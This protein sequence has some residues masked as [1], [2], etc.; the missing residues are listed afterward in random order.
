MRIG[1]LQAVRYRVVRACGFARA[2]GDERLTM[3]VSVA[4]RARLSVLIGRRAFHSVV[5]GLNAHP[6]FRWRFAS[7]KTDRLLIAPQDLRTADAT[8]ATEIYAGRFAFAGKV[9]ISDRRSPFQMTPPSDEWAV[10][11]L[12]FVWLRHLRAADSAITRS[13]ARSLIDEWINVQG[14]GHST[15][16][17]ID[18][19]SRRIICWLSQAPFVLQDADARFYRRFIRSLSRQARYL[20][21]TLNES[22]D[23]LPRLQAV[24]ALTYA[25][26]CMQGQSGYLRANVHRLTEELRKQVLPDGGHA[27]RNP[28]ALSELLAD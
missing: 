24:V 18:I 27:S 20:R 22:R 3:R 13:N 5:G 4:E 12:S 23:G 16:W 21:Q 15:G 6:L 14:G 25:A 1:P 7:T 10:T 17:R 26:L 11:L 28:G 9:V 19:L 8:R 2:T